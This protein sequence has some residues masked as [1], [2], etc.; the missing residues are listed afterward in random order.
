MGPD[1][2]LGHHRRG[3]DHL[4]F[5]R[6]LRIQDPQVTLLKAP[7]EKAKKGQIRPNLAGTIS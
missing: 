1:Q 3:D 6:Q 4:L 2:K 5:R 7:I